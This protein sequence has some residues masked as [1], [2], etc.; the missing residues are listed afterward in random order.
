MVG[1]ALRRSG[2]DAT[3]ALIAVASAHALLP[4]LNVFDASGFRATSQFWT[5]IIDET[6]V[7][8]SIDAL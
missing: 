7:S 3:A 1:S 6:S 8:A 4:N 5:Q 2:S